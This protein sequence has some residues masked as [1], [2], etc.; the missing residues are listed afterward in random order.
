VTEERR[1]S[2]ERAGLSDSTFDGRKNPSAP[3]LTRTR[4]RTL[5][6]EPAFFVKA[7][8]HQ[9]ER[10]EVLEKK[11]TVRGGRFIFPGERKR[12]LGQKKRIFEGEKGH[13]GPVLRG[14][15]T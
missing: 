10:R 5:T 13:S 12:C 9:G 4:G 8:F 15:N 6:D 11:R 2:K 1:C 7:A 3:V 14:E